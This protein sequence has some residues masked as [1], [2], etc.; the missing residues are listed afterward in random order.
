M[1]RYKGAIIAPWDDICIAHVQVIVNM[2]DNNYE[3][4]YR[5]QAVLLKCAGSIA[6]FVRPSLTTYPPNM[7]AYYTVIFSEPL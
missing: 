5:E 4:A 6:C 1:Q 7:F 3:E 2:M